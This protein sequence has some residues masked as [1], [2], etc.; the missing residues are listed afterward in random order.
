MMAIPI[1]MILCHSKFQVI[2]DI[3]TTFIFSG[4]CSIENSSG[5]LGGGE[6]VFWKT[7]VFC[8]KTMDKCDIVLSKQ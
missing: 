3:I 4:F 6:R 5:H 8:F 1:T 2:I 7:R